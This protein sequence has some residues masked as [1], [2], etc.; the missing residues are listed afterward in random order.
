M[1]NYSCSGCYKSSAAREV[2][3]V[4]T[5]KMFMHLPSSRIFPHQDFRYFQS[6][7][8]S[9]FNLKNKLHLSSF[10]RFREKSFHS[11]KMY[12]ATLRETKEERE[13]LGEERKVRVGK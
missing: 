4:H 5:Q 2:V 9:M 12:E 3:G 6:G 8:F 11:E 13:K 10:M 7:L 1:P